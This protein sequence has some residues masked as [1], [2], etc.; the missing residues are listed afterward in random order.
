MKRKL[1]LCLVLIG[2]RVIKRFCFLKKQG[3]HRSRWTLRRVMLNLK[4]CVRHKGDLWQVRIK[5]HKL[6]SNQ[7]DQMWNPHNIRGKRMCD[8]EFYIH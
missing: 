5:F 2:S 1:I 4:T 6:G 8:V 3:N 7:D